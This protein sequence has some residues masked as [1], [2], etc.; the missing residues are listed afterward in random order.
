[1]DYLGVV[2]VVVVSVKFYNHHLRCKCAA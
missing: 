1:L 2:V